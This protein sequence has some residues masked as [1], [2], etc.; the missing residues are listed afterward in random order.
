MRS[1]V[2]HIG[3]F[4]HVLYTITTHMSENIENYNVGILDSFILV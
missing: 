2:S 1:C 3:L 4:C